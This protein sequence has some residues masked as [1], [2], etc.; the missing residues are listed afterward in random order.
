MGYIVKLSDLPDKLDS[1]EPILDK[2][3][4]G[5][6]N[7]LFEAMANLTVDMLLTDIPYLISQ[8]SHGLRNLDYGEWDKDGN[9]E[10]VILSAIKMTSG[11]ASIFCGEKQLSSLINYMDNQDFLTRTFVW[12]KPNPT[13]INGQH[14]LLPSCEFAAWG[15]RKSSFFSGNCIHNFWNERSPL[16][17]EKEHPTQKPLNMILHLIKL[18][19]DDNK[20]VFDPFLGS[21]TT[22]VAAKKLGRH[23]I[24]CEINPDYC[25]IAERRLLELDAQPGLFI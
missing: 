11:T 5:D 4:E 21:G 22:A 25:K 14:I 12:H 3:V 18:S 1:I 23:F 17:E 2:I 19:C 16:P 7:E 9:P 13:V 8:E 6:C 20:L 24:G 15:K 10:Q